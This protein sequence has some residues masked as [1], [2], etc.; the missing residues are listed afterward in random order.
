MEEELRATALSILSSN[1]FILQNEQYQNSL[2]VNREYEFW[3]NKYDASFEG[4][5]Y[6]D[7]EDEDPNLTST[8]LFAGLKVD[9]IYERLVLVESEYSHTNQLIQNIYLAFPDLS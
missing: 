2:D 8:Q 6:L 4:N 1:L 3:L 9:Q 5:S 7:P